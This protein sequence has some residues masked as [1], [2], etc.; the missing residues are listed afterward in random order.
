MFLNKLLGALFA[1][2]LA[3]FGINEMAHILVHGHTPEKPGFA[4]EVDDGSGNAEAA[5]EKPKELSL[6]ELLAQADATKG[7]RVSKKCAA[8]HTF[9]QGEANKVG[10]NLWN[11]VNRQSGTH[12]GFKYSDAMAAFDHQW[13]FA[14]LNTFLTDPKADVPGTAMSFAGLPKATDRANLLAYLRTLS[15]NPAAFPAV[16]AAAAA[17]DAPQAA[18][19]VAETMQQAA[20]DT[21]DAVKDAAGHVADTAS[22][23]VDTAKAGAEDLM[24]SLPN[25][26]GK[27][28]EHQKAVQ[29]AGQKALE[30]MKKDGGDGGH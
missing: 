30:D 10:P 14:N 24:K 12:A 28:A 16:P 11:I 15:D 25:V 2:A 5:K 3:I 6:P 7:E 23:A 29:E 22:D 26:S 19:D 1:T 13:T 21:M 27:D 20:G 4:V 9:G 8:C 18:G 17:A